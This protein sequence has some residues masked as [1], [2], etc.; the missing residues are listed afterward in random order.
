[1]QEWQMLA[2]NSPSSSLR[3]E[4]QMPI[5]KSA[6]LN[7]SPWS[8]ILNR[9]GMF[10]IRPT[11]SSSRR[12]L[13]RPSCLTA[14][15][16]FVKRSTERFRSMKNLSSFAVCSSS[17][18]LAMRIEFTLAPIEPIKDE[19]HAIARR[20]TQIAKNLSHVFAGAIGFVD[21]V[22]CVRLQCMAAM[23]DAPK[24][25]WSMSLRS[26]QLPSRSW[27]SL[28]QTPTPYQKQ[29]IRWLTASISAR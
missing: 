17:S 18:L 16:T 21:G 5:R 29:A 14:D 12:I 11:S 27:G 28:D 10:L 25:D 3:R 20:I 15:C 26:S 23:Y 4:G 2:I 9:S 1:M 24:S 7:I 19:K 6:G 8:I 22:N 13:M